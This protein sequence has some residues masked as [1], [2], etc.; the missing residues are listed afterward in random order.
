[1]VAGTVVASDLRIRSLERFMVAAKVPVFLVQLHFGYLI[2]RASILVARRS[3]T[4]STLVCGFHTMS[5][6][7]E[8]NGSELEPERR[9]DSI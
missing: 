3:S 9:R 7:T 6:P 5:G 8:G 2:N 4:S 1:M